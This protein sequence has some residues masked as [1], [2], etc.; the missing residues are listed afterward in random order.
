MKRHVVIGVAALSLLALSSCGTR[1]SNS[2]A[3]GQLRAAYGTGGSNNAGVANSAN[4]AGSA[5]GGGA[6]PS[7]TNAD[8]NNSASQDLQNVKTFVE[9]N[10][11]I[12][13]VGFFGASG[14][15]GP[16]AQYAAQKHVP[17]VGGSGFEAEWTQYPS[18]FST[19]TADEA[20][21]YAWA[22]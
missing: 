4:G 22:A 21:D 17:V 14:G 3:A 5:G 15:I 1:L 6:D 2:E 20:Q 13:L 18:M 12:A 19:A 11:V 7:R 9:Q 16:V 8:D 10:H